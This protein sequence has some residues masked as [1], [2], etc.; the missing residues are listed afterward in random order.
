MN[1]KEFF[2]IHTEERVKIINAMLEEESSK[3]L[4]SVAKRIGVKY[5]TFT[6]EMQKDNYV[7][8]QRKNKYFKFYDEEELATSTHSINEFERELNFLKVNFDSLKFL[9]QNKN[10]KLLILDEDVYKK[11]NKH[12]TKTIKIKEDI[13]YMFNQMCEGQFSHYKIQDLFAQSLL[14]FCKKY[15]SS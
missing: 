4:E 10:K 1:E 13:Y 2:E 9:T 12:I 5:S 14:E 3:P 7:Y 8:I 15:S 6:K 11:T